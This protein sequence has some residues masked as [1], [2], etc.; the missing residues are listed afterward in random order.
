MALLDR[1]FEGIIDIPSGKLKIDSMKI[2]NTDKDTFTL[3]IRLNKGTNP[4]MDFVS[5]IEISK[6]RVELI[7]IKPVSNQVKIIEG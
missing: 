6:Y 5:E 2:Y 3:S 1:D 4:K 7:V